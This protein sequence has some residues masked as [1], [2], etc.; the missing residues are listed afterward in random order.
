ML[1][2]QG[3]LNPIEFRMKFRHI[4]VFSD[5]IHFDITLICSVDCH[6]PSALTQSYFLEDV[7]CKELHP[8]SPVHLSMGDE[9]PAPHHDLRS[10][11]LDHSSPYSSGQHNHQ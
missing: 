9:T 2:R 4:K 5:L 6:C 7:Q 3:V 8:H 11:E 10:L 1:E